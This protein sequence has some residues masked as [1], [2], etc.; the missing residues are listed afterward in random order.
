M[1]MPK[2]VEIKKIGDN[3]F[4]FKP[5]SMTRE[6]KVAMVILVMVALLLFFFCKTIGV[7]IGIID[8]IAYLMMIP[9]LLLLRRVTLNQKREQNYF[10]YLAELPM[11]A[12]KAADASLDDESR[13]A[14]KKFIER[15]NDPA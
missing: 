6:Q 14:V 5:E 3:E 9:I 13:L 1:K 11:E 2:P 12:I 4:E 10:K 15:Q 7:E 8:A